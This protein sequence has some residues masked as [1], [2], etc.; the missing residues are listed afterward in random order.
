[1]E[2]GPEPRTSIEDDGP[3]K[4][5]DVLSNLKIQFENQ[6][7]EIRDQH[8]KADELQFKVKHLE[9][10][11]DKKQNLPYDTPNDENSSENIISSLFA[12]TN[13]EPS[14][15]LDGRQALT[16]R[17]ASV[18]STPTRTFSAGGTPRT[19]KGANFAANPF[20][21]HAYAKGDPKRKMLKGRGQSTPKEGTP[22]KNAP[23][24]MRSKSEEHGG[25]CSKI[26]QRYS[27]QAE[28]WVVKNRIGTMEQMS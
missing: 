23:K 14:S 22:K 26:G 21:S 27:A 4:N 28:I 9:D 15:E 6:Q 1:M 19:F 10:E 3:T 11:D 17:K 20:S 2:P 5:D 13:A 24:R 18:V 12:T 16:K 8:D 7:K 25:K